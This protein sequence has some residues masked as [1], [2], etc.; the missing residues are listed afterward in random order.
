MTYLLDSTEC[1]DEGLALIAMRQRKPRYYKCVC[2]KY[3]KLTRGKWV[4]MGVFEVT[5]LIK[6][7]RI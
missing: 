4:E 2:G 1:C 5:R 3:Y 6:M 7:G